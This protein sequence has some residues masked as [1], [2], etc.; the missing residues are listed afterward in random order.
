MINQVITVNSRKFDFSIHKSWKARLVDV[1]GSLLT[2][3]GEFG[4][5]VVH[6]HLGTVREG[7]VSIE[8]FWLD[9]WFSVFRFHEPD[10]E[11][12]N[13]YCNINQ[14]PVLSDHG[15]LDYVDL[16]V[17]ILVRKDLSYEILDRDEF[18]SNAVAMGY[19]EQTVL[20]AKDALSEVAGL[21]ERK[22]FPFNSVSAMPEDA[23][24]E[25]I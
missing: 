22:E 21:I 1:N 15:V 24:K 4:S 11:F 8:Y 17:D 19:P 3:V 23:L 16:D 12:R 14:P 9:E 2:L 25:L 13:F 6:P 18:D 5:R 7:T 10:G 20:R